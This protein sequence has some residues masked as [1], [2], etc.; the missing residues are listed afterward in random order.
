MPDG[1]V[2]APLRENSANAKVST[3]RHRLCTAFVALIPVREKQ[4]SS[5]DEAI[6][7]ADAL[8][9]LRAPSSPV[10]RDNDEVSGL[11][12]VQ[13]FYNSAVVARVIDAEQHVCATKRVLIVGDR[14][15]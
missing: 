1:Y 12:T 9:A 10:R 7:D 4:T 8:L 6:I 2:G 15:I 3:V 13:Q 11:T 5:V 14:S